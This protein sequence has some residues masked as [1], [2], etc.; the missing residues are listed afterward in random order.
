MM[1]TWKM[2]QL[3]TVGSVDSITTG[4]FMC[5]EIFYEIFMVFFFATVLGGG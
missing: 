1:D 4:T 5:V 3:R 2:Q